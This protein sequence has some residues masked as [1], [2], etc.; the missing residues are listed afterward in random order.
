MTSFLSYALDG[1]AG[2]IAAFAIKSIIQKS[3]FKVEQHLAVSFLLIFANLLTAY[4]WSQ[5]WIQHVVHAVG[6]GGL[7]FVGL[8][9]ENK[10]RKP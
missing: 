1:T 2:I 5:E 4:F 7:L 9:N 6:S 3:L 8:N 10:I